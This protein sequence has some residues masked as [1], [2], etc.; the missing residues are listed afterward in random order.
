MKINENLAQNWE[1]I[2]YFWTK[3]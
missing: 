2:S 3:F 1:K